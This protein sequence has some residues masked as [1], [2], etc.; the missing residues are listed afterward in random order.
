MLNE[1]KII[2]DVLIISFEGELMGGT[3]EADFRKMIYDAIQEDHVNFVIDLQKIRWMNSSGLG[4]LISALTTARSSGGDLRLANV[5]ERVLRPIQI[6][7]LDTVFRFFNSV[8]EA[9]NSYK[10]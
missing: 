10:P 9:I 8:E 4:M 6:T 3:Q 5:S 2:D 1:I 7:K